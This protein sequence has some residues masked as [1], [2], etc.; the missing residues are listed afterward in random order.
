MYLVVSETD[1][2]DYYPNNAPT[3]FRIHTPHMTL[4]G[5]WYMYVELCKAHIRAEEDC[6]ISIFAGI[7]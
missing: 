7:R 3:D 2:L 1:F 4:K 5:Q 6:D